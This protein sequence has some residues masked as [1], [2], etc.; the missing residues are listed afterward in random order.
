MIFNSD[1]VLLPL[2]ECISD[3]PALP[4]RVR[5]PPLDVRALICGCSQGQPFAQFWG[6]REFAIHSH[7]LGLTIDHIGFMIRQISSESEINQ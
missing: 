7:T 6:R 1:G 3:Q 2:R 5:I 4:V